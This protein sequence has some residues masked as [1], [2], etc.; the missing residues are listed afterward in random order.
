MACVKEM[1]GGFTSGRGGDSGGRAE[2]W[3]GALWQG[4]ERN[5]EK[6]AEGKER[7]MKKIVKKEEGDQRGKE[8]EKG[9]KQG[10]GREERKDKEED[11]MMTSQ[12]FHEFCT[13]SGGR[14]GRSSSGVSASEAVSSFHLLSSSIT[15][16]QIPS[17]FTKTKR[18]QSQ[19][20]VT[21]IT[22][23]SLQG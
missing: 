14:S 13:L 15:C 16:K 6:S 4:S 21:K 18:P 10:R 11:V 9:E 17:F 20:D 2:K 7:T 1:V 12:L 23:T 22:R 8:R 19:Y 3:I 5:L